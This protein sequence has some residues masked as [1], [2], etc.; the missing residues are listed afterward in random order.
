MIKCECL[1]SSLG[2]VQDNAL[3]VLRSWEARRYIFW[4]IQHIMKEGLG[5]FR[6]KGYMWRSN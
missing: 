1:F 3:A 4:V 2:Q 6:E 5:I